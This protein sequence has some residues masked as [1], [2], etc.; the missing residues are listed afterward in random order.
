MHDTAAAFGAAFFR[1]YADVF[2]EA[3]ILE[4]GSG[5][6]NG[7]LRG[8]A[9][10]GCHY[11]GAD[12]A[13]GPGV[14]VVLDDPYSYPFEPDS[15]D[16]IVSSSC[17]EHD[18]MFWLSF[19]EM[20]R[21][22]RPGGFIYVNVPSNGVFHRYPTDNWRFY[23][24]SGLA[25]A[26]WGRRQGY[27][28]RFLEGL[29]G[30]RRGDLWNDCVLVFGKGETRPPVRLM[31][32]VFP[33]SF[34]I[35]VGEDATIT[36]FSEATEDMLLQACL[37]EKLGGAPDGSGDARYGSIDALIASV[38]EREVALAATERAAGQRC[39]ALESDIEQLRQALADREAALARAME[40]SATRDAAQAKAE[41]RCA[42]LADSL[43]AAN[44]AAAEWEEAAAA[45]QTEGAQRAAA[46][47]AAQAE[48]AALRDER[49]RALQRAAQ[50]EDIADAAQAALD[51]LRIRASQA[52]TQASQQLQRLEQE[53]Q[54]LAAERDR[55]ARER[56]ELAREIDEFERDW[57]DLTREADEIGAERDELA[58]ERD[59]LAES[60]A[61]VQQERERLATEQAA[62]FDAAVLAAKERVLRRGPQRGWRLGRYALQL[63]PVRGKGSPMRRAD[64][65]RDA[66][67]WARA[68]RLYLDALDQPSPD[69]SAIWV[70]LGHALKEAGSIAEAEFAYRRAIEIDR[71]Q[72]DGLLALGQLLR[73]QERHEEAAAV[74][75]E[76]L[77][78]A[79]STESR[80]FL[81]EELAALGRP[82]AG[83]GLSGT[84]AFAPGE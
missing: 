81:S 70:Q 76:A 27:D 6:V 74:Y 22:L 71:R 53:C 49:E 10:Y 45:A 30:R 59:E 77:K 23:P 64:Q 32:D 83:F 75:A 26:S 17:L 11:T 52:N 25:L 84:R 72:G 40:G 36:N 4:I 80:A 69:R 43:A 61:Q 35:R 58:R 28:I 37:A 2:D 34:N 8:C 47:T 33:R 15:F 66:Q 29:I 20:C 57:D 5:D 56:S 51:A 48:L 79:T 42:E 13:A 50:G 38:A 19:S 44:L 39:A 68:A 3:R 9:P 55:L 73:G 18:P 63:R 14:D 24:D 1:C 60:V 46:L 21:V 31:S 67:Q 78:L 54:T 82:P 41:R 7:S 62:W 12:L 16:A 65:A